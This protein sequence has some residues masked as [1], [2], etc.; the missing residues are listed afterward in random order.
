MSEMEFAIFSHA[1][2]G[3]DLLALL[4][5]VCSPGACIRR[6]GLDAPIL[7]PLPQSLDAAFVLAD[8][9]AALPTIAKVRAR[10]PAL[11]IALVS[12]TPDF[13]LEGI[14]KRVCDYLIWPL[15]QDDVGKVLCRISLQKGRSADEIPHG[16]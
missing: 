1:N 6:Y 4:L 12:H 3:G 13:A 7:Q 2:S 9:L 8:D 5:S 10:S 15:S 11:P 16:V 14:R